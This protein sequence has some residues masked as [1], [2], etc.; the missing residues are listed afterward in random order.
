MEIWENVEHWTYVVYCKGAGIIVTFT[1]KW[2][3]NAGAM[4]NY[5]FNL[6]LTL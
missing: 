2:K 6:L 1:V 3:I 4:I 5:M